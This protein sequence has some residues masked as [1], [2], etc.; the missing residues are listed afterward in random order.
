M[1]KEHFT[2]SVL[3]A[4]LSLYRVAK[5]ILLN[6]E[7]CADAIQNA[8]L[9]AFENLD[10]L[11]NERYFKTW[12][13]RILINECYQMLKNMKKE[14]HISL[15]ECETVN[16]DEKDQTEVMSFVYEL[17]NKYRVPFI[18]HYI[19]GYSI[20]EIAKLLEISA[21]NVK[22]RLYRARNILQEQLKEEGGRE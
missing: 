18:L 16:H 21:G 4:E 8:I 9:K 6:D 7:D 3:N 14:N 13:T 15:E 19:E 5:S 1:T 12:L 2:K 10:T 17:E 11:K 20:K 22:I